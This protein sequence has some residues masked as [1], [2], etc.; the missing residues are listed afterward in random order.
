MQVQILV[1]GHLAER[2]GGRQHQRE[3][4]ALA[5]PTVSALLA[6]LPLDEPTLAACAITISG[7]LVALEHPLSGGEEVAVLPPVSGG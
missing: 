7:E 2:C 1:F 3:L 4:T 6:T 5:T